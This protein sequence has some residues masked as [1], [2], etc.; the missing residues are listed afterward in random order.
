MAVNRLVRKPVTRYGEAAGEIV[1]DLTYSLG[2]STREDRAIIIKRTATV[3]VIGTSL[4]VA[5][6]MADG[7]GAVADGLGAVADG[8]GAVA[9][10]VSA[11]DA[12]ASALDAADTLG[13]T[14][15]VATLDV[16][17]TTNGGTDVQFGASGTDGRYPEQIDPA[18]D[19][20]ATQSSLGPP[21]DKVTGATLDP[22]AIVP[23]K[24]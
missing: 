21:M 1:A 9:D 12:G 18:T 7:V 8:A 15:G 20:P 4:L 17:T 5:V 10:G 16:D 14:D 11:I 22:K 13:A 24:T 19:H 2:W 23:M 6:V 3:T